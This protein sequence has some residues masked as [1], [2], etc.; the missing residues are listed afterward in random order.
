M[1]LVVL[2]SPYAGD[3]NANKAYAR[4]AMRDCFLRG[5]APFAS[6]LLYTQNGVLDDSLP[7]ERA[8]GISAGM[9]W[10]K[11]ADASV[12]YCDLGISDGMIEGLAHA[13]L[14]HRTIEW[15]LLKPVL[16]GYGPPPG[17]IT[18]IE[19]KANKLSR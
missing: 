7:E 8:V 13:M 10:A 17:I 18:Q 5:E 11:L 9:A 4:K 15:R 1:R 3:V 12:A 16:G 14:R 2:E 6:H 19:N